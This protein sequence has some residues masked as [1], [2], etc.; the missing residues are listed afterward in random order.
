M[1]VFGI[2]KRKEHIK[3]LNIYRQKNG[4]NTQNINGR[5]KEQFSN[6][7]RLLL[8]FFLKKYIHCFFC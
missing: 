6:F 8:Y 4:I 3:N 1:A 2:W 7:T 5:E